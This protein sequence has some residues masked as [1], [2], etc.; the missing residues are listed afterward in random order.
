MP[1]Q[2]IGNRDEFIHSGRIDNLYST[3]CGLEGL[4]SEHSTN[5]EQ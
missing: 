2:I 4:V 3:F 1:S 5:D